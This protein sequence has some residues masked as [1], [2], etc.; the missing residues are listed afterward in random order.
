MSKRVL[1]VYLGVWHKKDR[2]VNPFFLV[3][4][5]FHTRRLSKSVLPFI[6]RTPPAPKNTMATSSSSSSSASA[7]ASVP[8]TKERYLL[9]TMGGGQA[10]G[11][12]GG[13]HSITDLAV[14]P[15]EWTESQHKSRRRSTIHSYNLATTY[16]TLPNDAH[17]LRQVSY[18]Y[19]SVAARKI[20]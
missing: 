7:S 10:G 2:S 11:Q 20:V 3:T 1:P 12:A 6:H 17:T 9:P 8:A 16:H 18:F 15:P 19:L 4:E 14:P 13:H 5:A